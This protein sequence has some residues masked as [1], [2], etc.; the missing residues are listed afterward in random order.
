M[1]FLLL[2]ILFYE[3]I[4]FFKYSGEEERNLFNNRKEI[5]AGYLQHVPCFWTVQSTQGLDSPGAQFND[6]GLEVI[7]GHVINKPFWGQIE[8]AAQLHGGIGLSRL[9]QRERWSRFSFSLSIFK[10]PSFP[11]FPSQ[12]SDDM[13]LSCHVRFN[14]RLIALR[15]VHNSSKPICFHWAALHWS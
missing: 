13:G 5:R 3:K 1:C 8:A 7:L 4:E 10:R 9:H 12:S 2:Q 6:S 11:L 14:P 15:R